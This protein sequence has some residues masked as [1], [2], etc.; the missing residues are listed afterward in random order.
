MKIS[1]KIDYACRALIELALHWPD[2]TPL[3]IRTIAKR[4]KIPIKFLVHILIHLKQL[5]LTQSVRGKS[6]GYVLAQSPTNIKLNMII[7]SFGGLGYSSVDEK[8][9]H[10][11][12][13]V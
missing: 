13:H 5:G 10:P 6:G 3:Q 9:K 4:Q 7:K 11:D 2:R 1:A 12:R 8:A